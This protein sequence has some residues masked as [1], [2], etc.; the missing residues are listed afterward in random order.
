MATITIDK[1]DSK[2]GKGTLSYYA[3]QYGTTVNA[4][5]KANNISNP[6]LIREGASL[7]IPDQGPTQSSTPYRSQTQQ[8]VGD[9]N[10]T[11]EGI[12]TKALELKGKV[13]AKAAEEATANAN[14]KTE[15]PKTGTDTVE[16]PDQ[17]FRD[18]YE[19]EKERIWNNYE[20]IRKYADA[21]HNSMIDAIQQKF[22][23][24]A[25]R[26]RDSN[27][28]LLATKNVSNIRQGRNRYAPELSQGILT[29]EEYEGEARLADIE[30][31]LVMALA[32]AETARGKEQMDQ[33]NAAWDRANK[34][35]NDMNDQIEVNYK[36][37]I[38]AD[39]A[40]REK[41]KAER[42]AEKQAFTMMLDK[43]AAAAPGLV[44]AMEQFGTV[45]ERIAFLEEYARTAGIDMDVLVGELA[46]A[47]NEADYKRLQIEN[48]E[49]QIANR[50]ESTRISW[51]N[52]TK[53]TDK[54][55]KEEEDAPETNN[56]LGGISKFSEIED[57]KIRE[58]IKF[59]LS[60]YGLFESEPPQWFID[61]YEQQAVG[62][63]DT[64]ASPQ[65]VTSAWQEYRKVRGII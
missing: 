54:D 38:E 22:A 32:E 57:P 55:K 61:E 13:D 23:A 64:M 17:E 44:G 7:V 16:D 14:M 19:K 31:D 46:T 50:D 18:N 1:Y 26:M 25:E 53:K 58:Q 59:E 3:R 30:A 29:D 42:D 47:T 12:K 63:G 33:F 34:A 65:E 24:R 28:R 49:N 37:T 27:K 20:N 5:A 62:Q 60:Q 8:N 39:K 35:F 2:T 4:L 21:A 11:L 41:E 6:D 15:P 48:I 40:Q 43:A 56:I 9:F 10:A 45:E 36:R 51:Y 52:A